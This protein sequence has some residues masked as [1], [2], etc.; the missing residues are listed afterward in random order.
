MALLVLVLK[1]CVSNFHAFLGKKLPKCIS[2]IPIPQF[3]LEN[4]LEIRRQQLQGHDATTQEKLS[5][6]L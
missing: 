6:V 5:V 1:Q 3:N 2:L 4:T